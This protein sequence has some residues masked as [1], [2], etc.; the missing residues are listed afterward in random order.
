MR[1]RT[2][3]LAI[4]AVLIAG[5]GWAGD[6]VRPMADSV[7]DH[8]RHSQMFPTCTTCHEGAVN[9]G[10]AMYPQP[11][12]CAQCHDGQVQPR[13]TWQPPAET[14]AS[15]LRFTH[16]RHAI[17]LTAAGKPAIQCGACHQ[18]ASA[19]WMQSIT[20]AVLQGCFDC[21]GITRRHLAAPDTACATCHVPLSQANRLTR[22]DVAT[23][24]KPPSHDEPGFA[25]RGGHGL[26]AF[27]PAGGPESG[28]VAASC[29]TCHARDFCLQCHVD[30]PEQRAIQ[31]LAPDQRALAIRARLS[32][33]ESHRDPGFLSTHGV[34][35]KGQ[36]QE[37]R[38]CHTRESCLTCH[39]VTPR[40]ADSM[41]A[42]GTGRGPGARI[43]RRPPASHTTAFREGSHGGS[44]AARPETC[45]ACHARQ[46]C[47]TCHR[48]GGA[49]N[50]AAGGYHPSDFLA[51]HPA[52]AYSQ[53]VTCSDCHNTGAFCQ[54]C[55][56]QA[57]LVASGP[58]ARGF[59]DTKPAF[60]VGHGQ[61]ARQNLE[62]CVSC[63]VERDCL[64][65]HSAL[66]GRHFTP[67]GPGFDA[68]RLKKRNPSLCTACHGAA[69]P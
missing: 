45:A 62:S 54:S 18:P 27:H 20:P 31:A 52:A 47:L 55:H 11:Q 42:A 6:L 65:C 7:F 41:Y 15:N 13:I 58:L 60:I 34:I 29:A 5:A 56:E 9:P 12:A 67:H 35:A 25:G 39:E 19:A 57:G 1:N 36:P 17:R 53:Q 2:G 4:A 48:P 46:D 43:A 69:I 40:L 28:V 38:T 14:R 32:A 3:W 30:A 59:H 16:G 49:A 26:L 37:C 44:A 23:F 68:E 33:P 64:A 24:P 63:H 8:A 51:R 10:A 50:P 22:E 66:R 21:H 61:A